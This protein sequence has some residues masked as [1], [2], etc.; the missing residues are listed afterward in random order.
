[1]P[2]IRYNFMEATYYFFLT[3]KSSRYGKKTYF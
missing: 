2:E 1:M 3:Y